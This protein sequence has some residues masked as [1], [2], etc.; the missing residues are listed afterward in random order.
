MNRKSQRAASIA[1]A[2]VVALSSVPALPQKTS[3]PLAAASFPVAEVIAEVKRELAAAQST[4]GANV[5]ISLQKVA[6]NFA[7]TQ[8]TDKN[9][10]VTIGIP[11]LGGAELGGSGSRK[12]EE[13]SSLLVELAPPKGAGPAMSAEDVKDLGLTQ[14]IVSTRQQLLAGMSEKPQLDPAK[15]VITLKFA[16]TRTAGGTGQIKFLVFTIGGGATATS[17]NSSSIELTFAKTAALN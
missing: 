17:A 12:A 10:K 6:L 9:G 4:T 13:T 8:T 16:I 11:I 5:G 7:L 15:V 1:V 3:A 2:S 14:A